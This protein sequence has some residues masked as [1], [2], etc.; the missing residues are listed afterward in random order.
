MSVGRAYTSGIRYD[1]GRI[2]ALVMILSEKFNL[3]VNDGLKA[4]GQFLCGYSLNRD[5]INVED[6]S[7]VQSIFTELESVIHRDLK[8][9]NSNADTLFLNINPP[10]ME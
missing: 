2:V 10:L 9:I 4:F 6:Y 8:L 3:A 7:S 1:D 5:N